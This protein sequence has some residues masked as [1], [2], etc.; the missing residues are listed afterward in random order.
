MKVKCQATSVPADDRVPDMERR[1]LM[2]LLL[3]GTLSLPT[4]AMLVPYGSFFV[5]PG[6]VQLSHVLFL[7]VLV[8]KLTCLLLLFLLA[9][10]IHWV[11]V[12]D[13]ID[14]LEMGFC[15]FLYFLA[16]QVFVERP[17]LNYAGMSDVNF[18]LVLEEIP[19]APFLHYFWSLKSLGMCAVTPPIRLKNLKLERPYQKSSTSER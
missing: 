19:H 2:N 13:L 1:Q 10:V 14:V 8:K 15:G 16:S 7:F 18:D 9:R 3:L 4:A 5:P 11:C 6:S 12:S 17:V